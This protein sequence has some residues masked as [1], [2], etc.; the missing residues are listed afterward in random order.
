MNILV[1]TGSAHRHGS[2]ALLAD[3]FIEGASEAGHNVSRFDAAFK[4]VHPCIACEMCHTDGRCVFKDD[5]QE[6]NPLL[7]GAD[8]VVFVTPTYYYNMNAQIRAVI[9]RFYAHDSD[10][11]GRKKTA[12]L[13]A[14]A[15][16]GMKS[17]E[18][19]LASFEG[20]ANYLGWDIAGT[21]VGKGCWSL[22][23]TLASEYPQQ[24]YELGLNI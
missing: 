4:K 7:L 17:A 5:I 8:A 20:M 3:K 10:L 13:L 14:M 22:D 24:A 21:I 9:D 16:T 6:L 1:I 23:D 12:L 19:A 2:T 11:H 18:G 15:D